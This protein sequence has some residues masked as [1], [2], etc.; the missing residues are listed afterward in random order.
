VSVAQPQLPRPTA[1]AA[2]RS[3]ADAAWL[4]VAFLLG[5]ALALALAQSPPPLSLVVLGGIGLLA[6]LGL[7]LVRY[8]AV[9]A[10]GFVLFG[11]VFVEPAPPDVVFAVAIAVA[12]VTGRMHL[13]RIPTAIVLLLGF[14]LVLNVASAAASTY[15]GEAGRFFLVTAYLVVFSV[16]LTAWIDSESRMRL[17]LRAL[18]VAA[19][20]SAV[21]GTLAPF[22][23]LAAADSWHNDGRA[24]AFFEDPNVFGPFLVFPALILVEELLQP[25][26]L[27]SGR[28]MKLA[29]L[30]VLSIG[31]LFAYSRA[32][33]L[34]AAV[35]ALTMFA[36]F[37]LRR[38]GGRKAFVLVGTMAAALI[39]LF[40]AIVVSGSGE[41]F[42]ER[43]RFQQYDEDRFAAQR[44]GV[45]LAAS[46]PFGIG[47]GQYEEVVGYAAHSTYVNALTEQGF[48]GLLTVVLLF[49][50]T[51][52]AATR[53]A[54]AGRTT[55]G[56]GSATLLAAWCGTLANSVFVDT[57][58]WRHLWLI[59]ALIWIGAMIG[60]GRSRATSF[61]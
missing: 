23:P 36:V 57:L 17:V 14:F 50:V 61:L 3:G 20:F 26:L 22:L 37:A 7:A 51:L 59:A 56:I 49:L 13:R 16:W 30:F 53:N 33:W 45:E 4:A 1:E 42:E 44:A 55:F 54:V 8:A 10:L 43:A 19:V 34:N 9:V 25:R 24:K 47:P 38:G 15:P 21:V 2:W 29:L 28:A 41:F 40:G 39:V 60:P 31:V 6:L 58:H 27:R 18:L 35:A 48:L 52:A 5:G 11:I 46:H 12:I 32:A